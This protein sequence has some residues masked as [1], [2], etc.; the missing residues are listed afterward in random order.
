[1]K[2]IILFFS[3]ILISFPLLAGKITIEKNESLIR[4]DLFDE[5]RARAEEYKL[6]EDKRNAENSVWSSSIDPSCGLLKNH[7]LLYF[8]VANGGY[9]KGDKSG[10]SPQYRELSASE[11]EKI[12]N[13]KD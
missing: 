1:M 2:K 13:T 12:H 10:N 5:K 3:V 7:Y 6:N 8:C 11:V 9:Y 4:N